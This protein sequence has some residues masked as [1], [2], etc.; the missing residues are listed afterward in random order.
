[1]ANYYEGGDTSQYSTP[2]PAAP[3]PPGLRRPRLPWGGR[4]FKNVKQFRPWLQRHGGNMAAFARLHPA[5]LAIL[6]GHGPMPPVGN[7]TPTPDPAM[8]SPPQPTLQGP[9]PAAAADTPPAPMPPAADPRLTA[10]P[11]LQG[12]MHGG[13]QLEG[14]PTGMPPGM[15]PGMDPAA[16]D[17]DAQLRQKLIERYHTALPQEPALTSKQALQRHL[18][19][20][21]LRR[22]MPRKQ[23]VLPFRRSP[24]NL[25][26]Y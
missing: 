3:M 26:P 16:Y 17:Q 19:Q 22:R 24:R 25:R 10:F 18:M 11:A 8:Q 5:A 7:P 21:S 15:P 23:N 4:S 9:A 20:R 12:Q 14:G 1:M 13:A 2:P 6:R